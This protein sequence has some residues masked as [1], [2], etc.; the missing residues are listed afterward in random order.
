MCSGHVRLCII[1]EGDSAML[2]LDELSEK[3]S[4]YGGGNI[5][6]ELFENWFEDNSIGAYADSEIQAACAAVDAALAEYY[7]DGI[8]EATLRDGLKHAIASFALGPVY[9]PARE[10]VYGPPMSL[11]ARSS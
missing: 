4:A 5:S 3:I 9:A 1:L 6:F 2:S 8:D 10:I 7:F 11:S